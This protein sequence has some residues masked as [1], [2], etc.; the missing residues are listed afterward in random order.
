MKK[1][2]QMIIMRCVN[3]L[4]KLLII[5]SINNM[6]TIIINFMNDLMNLKYFKRQLAFG[7]LYRMKELE[8]IFPVFTIIKV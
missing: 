1:K 5:Y 7:Y 8:Y 6:I 2:T 4:F 3:L